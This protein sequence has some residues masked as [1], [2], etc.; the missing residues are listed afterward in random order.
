M[1]NLYNHKVSRW[2]LNAHFQAVD[3]WRKE[4]EVEK[5]YTA[6]GKPGYVIREEAGRRVSS[7]M[8]WGFPFNG[9]PV[10][11]VRNYT[12]PFWRSALQ[13]PER[14]CLVPVTEFQEWSVEPDPE[15]GKK[16]PYWFALPSQPVFAFAGIWRPTEG[17]P[18]FSFLTCGYD[19]DPKT[20]VVGAIH[21]KACP[22]I[23]HPEDYDRW[24]HADL[25]EALPLACA[26][27]SQLMAVR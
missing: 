10:T 12:S 17:H 3:D 9:K 8:I 19:G 15:T 13:N 27:P 20:H 26:Y 1:C 24:L 6:P 23:L 21:P 22:V 16:R 18:V 2:E 5:E 4:V 11:N 14:R 25:D 7:A